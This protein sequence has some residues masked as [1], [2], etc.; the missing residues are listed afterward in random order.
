MEMFSVFV[1]YMARQ[2]GVL[3]CL[4]K[5]LQ[6]VEIRKILRYDYTQKQNARKGDLCEVGG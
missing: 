5:F 1:I 3:T 4:E 2:L 6:N